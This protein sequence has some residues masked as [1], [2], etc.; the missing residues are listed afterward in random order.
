MQEVYKI[1]FLGYQEL[2]TMAQKNIDA[3]QLPDT[4]FIVE[5]CTP[6]KL[7]GIIDKAVADGY[8]IFIGGGSN[9]AEFK[10]LSTLHIQ[11][12]EITAIDYLTALQRSKEYGSRPAIVSYKYSS[13]VDIALLSQLFGQPVGL[14]VY[15]DRSELAD[16]IGNS[17]Y[18][19]FIGTTLVREYAQQQHRNYV[20]A[21]SGDEAIRTAILRAR[22][23]AI[24]LRREQKVATVNRALMQDT[25]IGIII[26]DERGYVTTLNA[27]AREYLGLSMDAAQGRLLG[28]VQKNLAPKGTDSIDSFK[29]IRGVRFRCTQKPLL[30][31]GEYIGHFT[32]LRI[33]NTKTSPSKKDDSTI[34]IEHTPYQWHEMID[35]S[36]AMRKAISYG[37]KIADS[38]LPCAIIGEQ[39]THK[40]LFSECLHSGSTRKDKPLLFLNLATIPENE[41]GR[42]LLGCIDP[43]TSYKGLL[44]RANGGSLVLMNL[45]YANPAVQS[46]L[47]EA[48]AYHQ[49]TP[50]GGY[51]QVNLDIR[52]ITLLD[53]EIDRSKINK[54]LYSHLTTQLLEVPPIRNRKEDLLQLFEREVNL[55]T[56]KALNLKRF[57]KAINL[58]KWYQWP[59]NL[60]ELKASAARFAWIYQELSSITQAAIHKTLIESI[61]KERLLE[62]IERTYS[63]SDKEDGAFSQMVEDLL[64]YV[65]MGQT[66]VAEHL[67]MS[68][69][70][71]WRKMDHNAK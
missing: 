47:L 20:M 6:Q 36:P 43:L 65:N 12:V 37:K 44:E 33:N 5:D 8:E 66:E 10:R 54:A 25:N 1:C 56:N 7:K 52:F 4:K 41:A 14:I 45:N 63:A 21:Y 68:R 16:L 17:N 69:T 55:H 28:E 30:L 42:Y 60:S 71:L 15:E 46:C 49:I 29:I 58:L 40:K 62:Q 13:P 32:T 70:T 2:T 57:Q 18:D 39:G 50:V 3:L 27:T 26:T 19:V 35:T 11:E 9:Y 53:T 51:E 22:N 31:K 59:G 67:G 48:V 38:P 24:S 34:A 23:R 64:T 61:G